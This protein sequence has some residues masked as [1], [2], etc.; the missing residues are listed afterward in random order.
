MY[1]IL[2]EIIDYSLTQDACIQEYCINEVLIIERTPL[3]IVVATSND[4]TSE[5][6]QILKK[7][8]SL[9]IKQKIFSCIEIKSVYQD[10]KQKKQIY[11]LVKKLMHSSDFAQNEMDQF[12]HL[13]IG[14]A[15][16]KNSSDIHI[17]TVHD[18]LIIRFRVDGKLLQ[19]MKFGFG[20][21]P[22]IS[23]VIKVISQLDISRKRLPQ[24]G[25]F[26]KIIDT[27]SYDFRVSVMPI[28]DGESIVIRILKP[29]KSS[30]KLQDIGIPQRSLDILKSTL[31][32]NQGLILVTGP[33]GSGKTTTMY[34]L[35]KELNVQQK[36]II[37]LEDPVEYKIDYMMQIA[38]DESIGFGY[39]QALK[40][41]LRQDPDVIMIGEIRD[42][43]TLQIVLSSLDGAFGI[44]DTAYK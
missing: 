2:H 42:A 32:L 11:L 35:L 19:I 36:K 27:N 10:F 8:F 24:N 39:A 13:L 33:T 14:L 30:N 18:G 15:I 5:I 25:R 41:I 31:S 44:S 16:Q 40:D 22:V 17:E 9:P 21:Y 3:N 43:S 20:F 28:N 1:K 12:F 4:I 37:T 6:S 7:R 38:I 26:S 34:S 29:S 23:A